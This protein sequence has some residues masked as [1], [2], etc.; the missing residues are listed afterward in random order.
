M[1]QKSLN[2]HSNLPFPAANELAP[3]SRWMTCFRRIEN[4]WSKDEFSCLIISQDF[5]LWTK[6][7]ERSSVSRRV[8]ISSNF[9]VTRAIR[10]D[11]TFLFFT[12]SSSVTITRWKC[13]S[14]RQETRRDNGPER[15]GTSSRVFSFEAAGT[16]GERSC[17]ETVRSA[18][19]KRRDANQ[20][21]DGG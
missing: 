21:S 4:S 5:I 7:Y 12:R 11:T 9:N 14:S 20:Y 16:T 10:N 18:L 8:K 1:K 19:V 13:F 6:T 2:L 3:L 17:V 15:S